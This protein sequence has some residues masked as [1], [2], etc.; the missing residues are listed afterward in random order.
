MLPTAS[1]LQYS[2]YG[3]LELRPQ[4]RHLKLRMDVL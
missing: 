4:L 3:K 1:E 2:V